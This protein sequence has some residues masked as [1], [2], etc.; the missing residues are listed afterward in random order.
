MI[1]P[2]ETLRRVLKRRPCNHVA[3]TN[4]VDR[5][6]QDRD[7]DLL[8]AHCQGD[9]AAFG[10]LVRRHGGSLLGYLMRMCGNR[11]QAEDFFQETFKRVHEKAHTLRSEHF[12]SWLFTIAT[13]VAISGLRR[14]NRLKVVSLNQQFDCNDGGSEPPSEI[15]VADSRH[16]PAE[17]AI[18]AEEVQQVRQAVASLPAKQRAVLILAYYQ[19]LSYREV[20]DI[21]GCSIGTVKTHMYRALKALAQRLPDIVGETE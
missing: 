13:R 3:G 18:K 16:N 17:Q 1:Y 14:G 2:R 10:E 6:V 15:A 12:N 20:A 8:D 9:R 5:Q 11:E 7:K 19:E 4:G 21:L